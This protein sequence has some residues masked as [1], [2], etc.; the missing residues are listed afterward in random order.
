MCAD[1]LNGG[2]GLLR[3]SRL[4]R[5]QPED[6]GAR[7][8][9]PAS[10]SGR[11]VE[12]VLESCAPSGAQISAIKPLHGGTTAAVDLIS[13]QG[14][15]GWTRRVVLR[16]WGHHSSKSEGRVERE[17]AALEFASNAKLAAPR[18]LASD[19]RAHAADTPSL[20]M[21]YV[22][23]NVQLR[24]RSPE[25][26]LCALA[27]VQ[28]AIHSVPVEGLTPTTSWFDPAGT[29]DW[30]P[31][32]GLRST[33]L[34]AA[35]S[36][37]GDRVFA[38]GDF[39]AFN[40]LWRKG[41]ISGVVDWTRA[42]VGLHSVD[43]GHFMLNLAALYSVEWAEMYGDAYEEISE[44]RLD[45][46]GVL[47]SLLCWRPGWQEFSVPRIYAQRMATDPTEM[48]RRVVELIRN[49]AVRLP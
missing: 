15:N 1:S 16:R 25:E 30:I 10:P 3:A 37:Q 21:S 14:P 46:G 29:Y 42:G 20:V 23:G 2:S 6:D 44:R 33:A 27:R 38:H 43:V 32:R 17:V 11:T 12:W 28:A 41:A 5:A 35:R 4:L 31:D 45:V 26:W 49:C 36:A 9:A 8:L 48:Q 47:V 22:L 24:P 13:L 7:Q 34:D 40:I 18:L 39:Q 19:A